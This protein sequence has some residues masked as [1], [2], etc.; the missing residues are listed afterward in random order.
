MKWTARIHYFCLASCHIGQGEKGEVDHH[1]LTFN[2]N[3]STL[4]WTD[5]IEATNF[6]AVVWKGSTNSSDLPPPP[7]PFVFTLIS[8]RLGFPVLFP[9]RNGSKK[10]MRHVCLRISHSALPLH[11]IFTSSFLADADL[12]SSP[13]CL[14]VSCRFV[15][16]KTNHADVEMDIPPVENSVALFP[17][18]DNKDEAA[19]RSEGEEAVRLVQNEPS[20]PRKISQKKAVEQ[21]NFSRWL[22]R[23]RPNLSK[24]TPKRSSVQQESLQYM[25]K[26]C[27]GGE[28][29]IHSPRDYQL[30]L[31]ER[32]KHENTI[33][34]LDTGKPLRIISVYDKTY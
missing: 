32:A 3:T 17:D 11:N 27:E 1:S 19:Y 21:A 33:A 30:E 18:D 5:R 23:N 14:G 10:H 2:G 24:K 8:A 28:K 6:A 34:V 31:F 15:F 29:I 22:S 7:F 4:C 26:S 25:I 20:K 12:A 9:S 13:L 16:I